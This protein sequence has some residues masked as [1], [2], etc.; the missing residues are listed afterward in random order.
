[1][2]HDELHGPT[3]ERIA[4]LLERIIN[5]SSP[6]LRYPVGPIFESI[7]ITLKK[8]LPARLFEWGV[9]KYYKL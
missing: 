9:M 8:V 2:E 4:I 6:R 3:P 5:T 1:M 7:A